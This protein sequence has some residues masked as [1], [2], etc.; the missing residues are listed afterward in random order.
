V[1]A[2]FN[3]LDALL[4]EPQIRHALAEVDLQLSFLPSIVGSDL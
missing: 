1:I 4:K 2:R 3:E